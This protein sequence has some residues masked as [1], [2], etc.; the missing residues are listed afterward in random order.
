MKKFLNIL[1]LVL[2]INSLKLNGQVTNDDCVNAI[3]LGLLSGDNMNSV[4]CFDGS[5]SHDTAVY[6]SNQNAIVNYPYYS[7]L[8]CHGYINSTVPSND[9]WYK[10]Q[11]GNFRIGV[12][13]TTSGL[14]TIHLSVWYGTNCSNL[15]PSGCYTFDFVGDPLTNFVDFA[16][17]DSLNDVF[18]QFSGNGINRVGNFQFCL[19]ASTLTSIYYYG[20]ASIIIGVNENERFNE[21][22]N[23]S[24]NILTNTLKI[25]SKN[26]IKKIEII[27]PVGQIIYSTKDIDKELTIS[28]K[29]FS[30]GIY[31]LN[32]SIGN[33]IMTKKIAIQ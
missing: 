4:G 22:I 31:L 1:S 32:I 28:L 6:S 33:K 29:D 12:I 14:D 18:L 26:E 5:F 25:A 19:S 23:I 30:V 11:T 9:V 7:M 2:L 8:G 13:P 20:T 10:M 16:N 27:N 17:L 21:T 24:S 15:S 3:D